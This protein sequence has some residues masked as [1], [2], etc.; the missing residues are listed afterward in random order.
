MSL[1]LLLSLSP[2]GSADGG[3]WL[4]VFS[5]VVVAAPPR[6]DGDCL[7]LEGPLADVVRRPLPTITSMFFSAGGITLPFTTDVGREDDMSDGAAAAAL[8]PPPPP[9]ADAVVEKEESRLGTE[10]ASE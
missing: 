10:L 5:L 4:A 1:V 6:V 7:A 9:N 8:C 3:I 2:A